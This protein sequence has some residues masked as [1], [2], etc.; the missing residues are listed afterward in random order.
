ML[1]RSNGKSSFFNY[2]GCGNTF[3]ANNGAAKR[4]ILD[5]LRHWRALTRYLALPDH[6]MHF[7]AAPRLLI[8][9]RWRCR[10]RLSDL[11]VMFDPQGD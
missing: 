7:Q 2:S 10:P 6:V 1:E 9:R 8:V 4:F 11:C 3:N 5:S